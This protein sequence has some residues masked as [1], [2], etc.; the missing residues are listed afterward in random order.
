MLQSVTAKYAGGCM[1]LMRREGNDVHFLGTAFFVH[2][3]GYLL[4]AAH[5]FNPEDQ[6]VAVPAE[7]T[8]EFTPM[9]LERVDPIPLQV[10]RVDPDR[11]A[12][13]LKLEPEMEIGVP[14]RIFGNPAE[15][16]KGTTVMALGFSFGHYRLHN[17]IGIH[18]V[19]A[20]KL[21]SPNGTR[22]LLFDRMVHYGDAGAPLVNA[23]DGRV[24]GI[25][26]GRFNLTELTRTN[27][28]RGQF[29]DI[30]VSYAVSIE[31]P[32]ELMRIEGLEFG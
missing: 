18:A 8:G 6:L 7:E 10:V 4:T 22:I 30:D 1:M 15:I 20:G 25:V 9:T 31:Y 19:L 24:V 3:D 23:Q 13:L 14:G 27:S 21:I 26:S 12:A 32:I 16:E 11:D 2:R 17:L 29:T 28:E 5:N